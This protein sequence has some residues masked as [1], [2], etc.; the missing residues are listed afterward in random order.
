MKRAFRLFSAALAAVS[1]LIL[2]LGGCAARPAENSAADISETAAP[3]VSGSPDTVSRPGTAGRGSTA[4]PASGGRTTAASPAPSAAASAAPSAAPSAGTKAPS[5]TAANVTTAAP[6]SGAAATFTAH[7]LTTTQL[8]TMRYWLYTPSAPAAGMPLI[9]YL[10]G[11][12]GKGDDL[13]LITAADG[14]PR[15][16]QTGQLG[17]VRAYV[18]IPQLPADQKGWANAAAAL[19]ELIDAAV[20][21]YRIDKNDISLTGHSM[22]GTGTWAVASLYP[23]LFSRIAPLSGSVRSA[24][25]TAEKL[26]GVPVRAF[27]GAADTIVPPASS[28]ETVAAL[29]AAGG[30]AEITVFAGADHF[31]VPPLTYL[32]RDIDLIGWLIGR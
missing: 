31:S 1:A 17:D 8:G 9:V 13:E 29:K 7:S 20:S 12:S 24:A 32:D 3:T 27:V 21:A 16:L 18:L 11:G 22:G 4:H 6:T 5:G 14:L 10:H 30:D 2:P 26:K 23:A 28:E 25:E 15:Y 19:R